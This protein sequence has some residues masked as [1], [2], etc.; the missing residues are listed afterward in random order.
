MRLRGA[1]RDTFPAGDA[2]VRM[3]SQLRFGADPFGIVT[4]ETAQGT[5]LEEYRGANTVAVM[6]GKVFDFKYGSL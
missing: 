6:D 4:P 1:N 5:P 2:F 3:I